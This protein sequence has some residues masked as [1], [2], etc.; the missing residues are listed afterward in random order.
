VLLAGVG[1]ASLIRTLRQT[2]ARLCL[3]AILLIGAFHL[4][5]QSWQLNTEYAA[6][7]RN[8]Y[9]YAQTSPDLL[10][11]VKSAEAVASLSPEGYDTLS[12]WLLPRTIT[13]RF[14]GTSA[15]FG[16]SVGGTKCPQSLFA[17]T[18]PLAAHP[19]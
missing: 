7:P 17:D 2:S 15:G 1:A 8:P 10:D 11:L 5:W 4:A 6:D 3:T 19:V 18:R 13:G 12:R 9:V 14:P 16:T